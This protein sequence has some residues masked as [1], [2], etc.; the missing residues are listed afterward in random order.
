RVLRLGPALLV[1]E[2]GLRPAHLEGVARLVL[3]VGD[4]GDVLPVASVDAV[5]A[6]EAGV[7]ADFDVS[8]LGVGV[9]DVAVRVR[10]TRARGPARALVIAVVVAVVLGRHPELDAPGQELDR[11]A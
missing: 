9:G 7:D 10:A 5:L 4:S 6:G 11:L 3:E 2:A 1:D 8:R